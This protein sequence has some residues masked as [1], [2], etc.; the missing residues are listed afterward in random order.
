MLYIRHNKQKF[1][2]FLDATVMKS[3]DSLSAGFRF[4]TD[5]IMDI[6]SGE[7]I[8]IMIGNSEVVKDGV[9]DISNIV[10]DKTGGRVENIS[11]RDIAADLIDSSV[12]DELKKMKP[13]ISLE[14]M[15]KRMLKHID[16]DIDVVNEVEG[17]KEF[18]SDE[19]VV[20]ESGT[21][22]FEFIS[23]Y[24]RK[25][26]VYFKIENGKIIIYRIEDIE[27][28]EFEFISGKNIKSCEVTNSQEKRYNTYICKSQA[29]TG[30]SY[31]ENSVSRIGIAT[32]DDIRESRILEFTAEENMSSN[33]CKQRAEEEA[34]IRR[35]RSFEYTV[36]VAGHEQNGSVYNIGKTAKI[37]D[38]QKKISGVFLIKDITFST[39]KREGDTSRIILTDPDAY[40]LKAKMT[41]AAKKR[42]S[43]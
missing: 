20:A 25:R 35:A 2:D 33:E 41:K 12:P 11:G 29:Q 32:D 36:T 27:N 30:Y 42:S 17:L 8:S 23:E 3:M 19:L 28:P 18:K 31:S 39:S 22:M 16:L 7:N 1:Y 24:A 43:R 9:V 5:K 34:N 15:V 26:G 10:E 13:G 38:A 37:K 4:R 6:E 21:K 14:N 40:S